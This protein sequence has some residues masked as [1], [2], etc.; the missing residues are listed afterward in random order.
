MLML[1]EASWA[2]PGL[3]HTVHAIGFRAIDAQHERFV[4]NLPVAGA[5]LH[6]CRCSMSSGMQ[7]SM[8]PR[9]T[10]FPPL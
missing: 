6:V 9:V 10:A 7:E 4:V 3:Q 1:P 8:P 5:T 2:K